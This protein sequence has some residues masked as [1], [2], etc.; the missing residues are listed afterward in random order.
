VVKL[1]VRHPA[2]F[3]GAWLRPFLPAG[4]LIMMRKQLLNLKHLAE[5]GR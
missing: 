4:D 5:G 1:L 2:R 3:P